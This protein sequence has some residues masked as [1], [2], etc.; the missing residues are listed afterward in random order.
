VKPAYTPSFLMALA[1]ALCQYLVFG[2]ARLIVEAQKLNPSKNPLAGNPA[3]GSPAVKVTGSSPY[4]RLAS[5]IFIGLHI[6]ISF[7][8]SSREFWPFLSRGL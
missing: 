7:P 2:A 5:E 3:P 4:K 8:C 1:G 6:Q